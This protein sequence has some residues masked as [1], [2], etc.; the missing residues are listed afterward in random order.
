MFESCLNKCFKLKKESSNH[1]DEKES[2]ETMALSSF[3]DLYPRGMQAQ[4]PRHISLDEKID[5]SAHHSAH[6]F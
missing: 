4:N 1:V 2:E 6:N 3:I 5:F